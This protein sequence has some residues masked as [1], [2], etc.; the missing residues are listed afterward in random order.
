[1]S[2][3]HTSPPPQ[4]AKLYDVYKDRKEEVKNEKKERI[5]EKYGGTE[6]FDVQLSEIY[7]QSDQYQ[8]YDMEGNVVAQQKLA[9]ARS[10]Y[11]EDVLMNGHST[12][13][14]SW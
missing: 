8:E 7:A 3:N 10:K 11:A 5:K 1:V 14:G 9:I 12:V 2:L 4:T 13:W 6:H